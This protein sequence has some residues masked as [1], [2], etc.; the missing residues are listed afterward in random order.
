[1]ESTLRLSILSFSILLFACG[2]ETADV[3]PAPA[4][5][6]APEPA[7]DGDAVAQAD[8]QPEGGVEHGGDLGSDEVLTGCQDLQFE[9]SGP[10]DFT[11]P[12]EGGSVVVNHFVMPEGKQLLDAKAQWD[13]EAWSLSM[14][15]GQSDSS[16]GAHEHS[17]IARVLVAADDV[18]PSLETFP[19]GER[20]FVAVESKGT[21]AAGATISVTVKGQA[22]QR[23]EDGP[24]EADEPDEFHVL[25]APEL[26]AK[27]L[28][29][30]ALEAP[31]AEEQPAPEAPAA[32]EQPVE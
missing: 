20:W 8:P 5:A 17:E 19:G 31:A 24:E 25:D 15:A 22:C 28:E 7:D 1:V 13:D 23:E 12:A 16:V 29:Q 30:T 18:D 6:P 10:Q 9:T 21:Q 2:A 14:I 26:G 4:P 3:T 11:V 27:P 32:E